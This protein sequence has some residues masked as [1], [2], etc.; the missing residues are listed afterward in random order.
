MQI[1]LYDKL[2][3]QPDFNIHDRPT[4]CDLEHCE[5]PMAHSEAMHNSLVDLT[6]K[7]TFRQKTLDI[8]TESISIIEA[9]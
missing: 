2:V 8:R 9:G 7:F 3:V 6:S 1:T 4:V 5:R